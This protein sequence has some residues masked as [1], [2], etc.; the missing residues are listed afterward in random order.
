MN[1]AR[2]P[3]YDG[4]QCAL[5]SMVY[6]CYDKTSLGSN[7]SSCAIK[8]KIILNQKLAE[9]LHKPI[10]AKFE[11][12]YFIDSIWGAVFV[13]MQLIDKF[14]KGI[15]FLLCVIDIFSK[16]AWVFPKW[17]SNSI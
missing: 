9:E 2:D 11:T 3:K 4:Y 17:S 10:I 15:R 12:E 6:Q 8:S 7:T 14:N 16:Y 5:A 1:I 13:D